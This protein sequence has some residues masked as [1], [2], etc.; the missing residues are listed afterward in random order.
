MRLDPTSLQLF[1][2]VV[3]EGTIAAAAA[4]E[5]IAPAAVG[6]RLS[7][8]EGVLHTSLFTRSNKGIK[9]T[10]AG[11]TLMN[12]ARRV[13]HDIDDVY[14]QMWEYSRGIKGHVRIFA[15][16]SAITQFLPGGLLWI[17][18]E[19]LHHAN[20]AGRPSDNEGFSLTAG[21]TSDARN[22]FANHGAFPRD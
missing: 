19:P 15:N 20:R 18:C 22:S 17:I 7:E 10:P 9:P 6:R 14:A 16:I 12:L 3:E 2:R 8:L 11:L 5:H 13:L 4:R 1:V 21:E